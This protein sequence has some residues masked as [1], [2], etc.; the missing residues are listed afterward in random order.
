MSKA[1]LIL[2][3]VTSILAPSSAAGPVPARHARSPT[4]TD[5]C[6]LGRR[7]DWA[8]ALG[9]RRAL[10]RLLGL[11]ASRGCGGSDDESRSGGRS[12]RPPETLEA[13]WRAPGEDVAV[14]AGT[15]DHGV[16]KHRVSFL[17]VD[18][19]SRLVERPTAR[20]WIARGLKQP[21]FAD[22]HRAARADR[23]PG[24]RRA[25]VVGRSTS[26]SSR[27]P[28]P[29]RTGSSPSRSAAARSRRSAT[30]SSASGARRALRRRPGDRLED[31][32]AREH[33]RQPR[34]ADDLAA[35]RP[36]AL[37]RSV[38]QALA[39]HEPFVVTVRDAAVL[40]S[41]HVRPDASTWSRPSA[42]G[43]R[44]AA[45]SGSSTSRSTRTTTP[46]R[47]STAGCGSGGFRPSRS[48]SSSTRDGV[49]R[50]QLEGAFSVRELEAVEQHLL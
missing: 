40:P 47:A 19:Q 15:S 46:R 7:L 3:L 49:I 6:R 43:W 9:S 25:G 18:K 39:A 11:P 32:D 34:R 42:S 38:A 48:R 16:G 29:G 41:A 10:A 1:R 2:A 24:R 33:G 37:P 21:P 5:A 23:R 14:V 26:R 20:V 30:S 27:L 13:L 44:S 28:T 12:R 8:E 50:A 22:A 4:A 17:V 45:A 35:A 31:A 36:R